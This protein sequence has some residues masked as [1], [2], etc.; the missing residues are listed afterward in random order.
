MKIIPR[1]FSNL[2]YIL[3]MGFGMS[4]LMTL[5]ITYINTGMDSEYLKRFF[6]AWSVGLP[7]AIIAG[8]IVGP[9]AKKFVDFSMDTAFQEDFP[10]RMWVFP[11]NKLATTSGVFADFAETLSISEQVSPESIDVNRER[12]IKEWT[13]VVIR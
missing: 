7:I 13:N 8:F 12:W 6:K 9:L 11:T 1:K 10:T 2:I 3:L 5:I 4:L